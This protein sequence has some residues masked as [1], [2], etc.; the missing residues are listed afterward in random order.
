MKGNTQHLLKVS[1]CTAAAPNQRTPQEPTRHGHNRLALQVSPRRHPWQR[2]VRREEC[3]ACGAAAAA[4]R[5]SVLQGGGA[6][7]HVGHPKACVGKVKLTRRIIKGFQ[8]LHLLCAEV[9]HGE[10]CRKR[11]RRRQGRRHCRLFA[12]AS[13]VAHAQDQPSVQP[14]TVD[15]R[16][17]GAIFQAQ[18]PLVPVPERHHLRRVPC[19]LHQRLHQQ[20]LKACRG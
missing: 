1:Q 19:L 12:C 10:C 11:D 2:A 6:A 8:E 18:D 17:Q 20:P 15:N 9:G 14:P 16:V 5:A 13:A 3:C 7:G 4:G